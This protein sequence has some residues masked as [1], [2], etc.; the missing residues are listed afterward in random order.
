MFA[1]PT[2]WTR[3]ESE[4]ARV[5]FQTRISSYLRIYSGVGAS[6]VALRFFSALGSHEGLLP[7][8][9]H[10]SFIAHVV[11]VLVSLAGWVFVRRGRASVD[12][13]E[14]IETFALVG[15]MTAFAAMGFFLPIAGAPQE[16]VMLALSFGLF[17]RAIYVPSSPRRSL[18]LGMSV[19]VVHLA[20]TAAAPFR[21]ALD[22]QEARTN[23]ILLELLSVFMDGTPSL[24]RYAIR[25]ALNMSLWWVGTLLLTTGAS[26]VLYNLRAEVRDVK[27]LGQYQLEEKLG[28]GGMGIVYRA[29]HALLQRP[30]AVK[31]LPEDRV[32]EQALARFE[33]EV[34]LTARLTHP[35]T[36]TVFDYGRTADGVFY[37]AMEFLEGATLGE[38]VERHG[39]MPPARVVHVLR[40]VCASLGE[41]HAIGL[42]H[43]DIKPANIMLCE[44]GGVPDTVKVLDFGLVKELDPPEGALVSRIDAIIGTP[45]YMPPEALTAPERLDARSD[46]YSLGATAFYLLTG[47]DVFRGRTLVEVCTHQLHSQ[48]RDP[49][50][51]APEVPRDLADIVLACLAKKQDERPASAGALEEMLARCSSAGAWTR[52]DARAFWAGIE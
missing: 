11:G 16:T 42:I 38:L 22:A 10:P 1:D 24:A 44:R 31:L 32:G 33:R 48:P 26:R 28:E 43:R 20:T 23:A 29:S 13:L 14:R 27:R 36:V 34:R 15:A 40:Q 30:A 21:P 5:F 35:N 7:A 9:S 37:Y 39:R 12:V 2:S 19:A 50:T 51:L 25:Q 41:A 8:I 49:T 46:L 17:A 6:F 47:E 45:Q 4:E 3:R 52:A 18:V